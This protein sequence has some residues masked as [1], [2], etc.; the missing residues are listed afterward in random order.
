MNK[1]KVY[2]LIQA[3]M[4]SSRLP[5]KVLKTIK[6]KTLI[7]ILLYRL[8]K[9]KRSDK[10]IVLTSKSQR[11]DILVDHLE[12][13]SIAYYRG[14]ENDVLDR[15][16]RALQKYPC[17][18]VVRITGDCPLIDPNLLDQLIDLA[19]NSDSDYCSNL[20]QES[21]PDGQDIEVFKNNVLKKA[22]KEAKL[23]SEREHV[24]PYII[25]NT[26]LKGGELFKAKAYNSD[27][28]YSSVR[29]TVDTLSDFNAIKTLV[30]NLGVN[31]SWDVY[32]SFILKNPINFSNQEIVRNLGYLKS[33]KND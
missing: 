30:D 24:T 4:G 12:K 2:V 33:L 6:G 17:D 15:Y 20:F 23:L 18:Y 13:K 3:R 28:D 10:L 22:W 21:F 29:M 32:T 31:E 11:D 16:Y 8:T 19:I 1:K 26:D 14:D 5:G 25:K 9:S 27:S 7:E